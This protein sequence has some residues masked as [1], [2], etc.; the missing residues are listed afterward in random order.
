MTFLLNHLWQSTLFAAAAALLTLTLRKHRAHVRYWIWFA[1]S[2]KFLIPFA[3]LLTLGQSIQWRAPITPPVEAGAAV[4]MLAAPFA[5]TPPLVAKADPAARPLV[6]PIAFAIAWGIGSAFILCVWLRRWR[7]VATA[8]RSGSPAPDALRLPDPHGLRVIVADTPLEPG[9]F[10]IVRPVLLWPRGIA[11]RLSEEQVHAI[12]AHELAHHRRR[13]NLTAALH[14]LVQAAFWFHPVV[15]W[16]GGRLVDERERACDEEVVRLGSAPEIYAESILRTCQFSI[17]SALVCVSGVTGSDLKKRMEHIMSNR[18]TLALTSLR[19]FALGVAAAAAFLAPIVAGHIGTV[20]AEAR[21]QAAQTS[22]PKP[23]FETASVKVNRS[24]EGR[25]MMRN[26]PGGTYEAM[27]VTVRSMIQ[28]AWRMQEFQ[29]INAP[30]WLGEERIDIV[31]KSPE[32]AVPA[33]FPLRL[34]SLFEER[35]RL[36]THIEQRDAPIYALV[37]ARPDGRLGDKIKANAVDCT[38]A[39][40]RATPPMPAPARGGGG[41]MLPDLGPLGSR[42]CT[43]LSSGG[44]LFAGGQ[45]MAEIARVLQGQAGRIVQDRT[46]LAGRFDFD[47]TFTPDPGLRGAGPG[48]GLPGAPPPTP[49]PDALSIFTAVQEQLGLK[50]EAARGPVDAL[51][52]DSVERLIE[53]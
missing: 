53:N 10:G 44:R 43:A 15:W 26:L 50:L 21:A 46:G 34:Q 42:P 37:L 1:A 38:S 3:L 24:G 51:V 19:R 39:A 11:E 8:V 33:E 23:A 48:G 36:K 41:P 52:I 35:F 49:D 13:D 6:P 31:A 7:R 5:D 9:I 29:V 12:V 2:M 45:T 20:T 17:E 40:G 18:P 30:A 16:I 4:D 25:V 28:Q 32:G 27:N 14:M 47:L 22:G